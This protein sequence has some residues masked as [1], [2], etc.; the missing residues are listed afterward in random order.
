MLA[1][2]ARRLERN[3]FDVSTAPDGEKAK[4]AC[5]CGAIDLDMQEQTLELKAA[6]VIWATGWRPYDAA[7][8]QPYGYGRFA[9]VVT[10]VEF[11]PGPWLAR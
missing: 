4:R 10:S 3:G 9:N 11:E 6:A 8:I 5:T 1:L 2:A 7:K